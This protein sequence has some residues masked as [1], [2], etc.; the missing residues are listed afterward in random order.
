MPA[1]HNYECKSCGY[2]FEA[3]FELMEDAEEIHPCPR[4]LEEAQREVSS[5][6]FKMG[7]DGTSNGGRSPKLKDKQFAKEFTEHHYDKTV[8]R[9]ENAGLAHY[10]NYSYNP[11]KDKREKKP[12]RLTQEELN[13]KVKKA[14]D[15]TIDAYKRAGKLDELGKKK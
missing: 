15:L 11:D 12:K 8:Q 7:K 1:T 13:K 3:F 4:C 2:Y 5:P 6:F 14:Q 10:R 9:M